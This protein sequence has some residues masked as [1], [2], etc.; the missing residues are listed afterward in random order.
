MASRKRLKKI[1]KEGGYNHLHK[2]SHL[3]RKKSNKGLT[4]LSKDL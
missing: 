4:N 3:Q 1:S 2:N